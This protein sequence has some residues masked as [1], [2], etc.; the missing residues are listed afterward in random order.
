MSHDDN[1]WSK[2]L[3][4]NKKRQCLSLSFIIQYYAMKTYGRLDAFWTLTLVGDEW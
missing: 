1:L 3:V 4:S 2:H